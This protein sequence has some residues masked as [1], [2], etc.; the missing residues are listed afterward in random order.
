VSADAQLEHL[1]SASDRLG[2]ARSRLAGGPVVYSVREAA[3]LLGCSVDALE[4]H[5]ADFHGY[6]VGR[7]ILFPRWA[8]ERLISDPRTTGATDDAN[9]DGSPVE[10]VLSMLPFLSTSDRVR[11][12]QT[13][14]SPVGEPEA[15]ERR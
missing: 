2:A 3:A 15:D 9:R 12:A 6:R 11:V 1:S 5:Y 7:R 8:I 4:R 14:L 10:Y 13:A